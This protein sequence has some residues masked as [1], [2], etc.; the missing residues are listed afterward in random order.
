MVQFGLISVPYR[1]IYRLSIPST[2]VITLAIDDTRGPVI[3]QL[4]RVLAVLFAGASAMAGSGSRED[5][6]VALTAG[7]EH[8]DAHEF[9]GTKLLFFHLKT[10]PDQVLALGPRGPRLFSA[11]ALHN[12]AHLLFRGPAGARSELAVARARA[13]L[14]ACRRTVSAAAMRLS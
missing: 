2:R 14:H 8:G 1:K 13:G 7:V 12:A 6:P 10:P 3:I 11:F 9:D 4:V 5:A